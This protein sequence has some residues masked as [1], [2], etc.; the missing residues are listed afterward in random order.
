MRKQARLKA[1]TGPWNQGVSSSSILIPMAVCGL[2]LNALEEVN[3][4]GFFFK[5]SR[6]SS[7]DTGDLR[8]L[9]VMLV[10]NIL[11]CFVII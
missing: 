2:R 7:Y 5:S 9:C 6:D 3:L 4:T 11:N 1:M 10:D 8:R